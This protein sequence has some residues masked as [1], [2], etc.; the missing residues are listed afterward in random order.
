MKHERGT[1]LSRAAA[2]IIGDEIL[3][4]KVRDENTFVLAKTLFERGVSL[5]KVVVI[6]DIVDEIADTVRAFSNQFDF[7]FTSGGIGPTHD[8]KT[9]EAVAKAFGLPL[10]FQEAIIKRLTQFHNKTLSDVKLNDAQKKMLFLPKPCE[11]I[12][13]NALWLPL[14]VVKN[15]YV[16]PGV[17]KLFEALLTEVKG[18]FNGKVKTRI[19][20]YTKKS[21]GDIAYDLGRLQSAYPQI[22]IGSY[23][24]Y[25]SPKYRVMVSLEGI[26][27]DLVSEVATKVKNAIDG[28]C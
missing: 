25:E 2:I 9:Y 21:E 24:K 26:S 5:Q 15:V 1:K 14:V 19:L 28:F 10:E 18:R 4:G 7:V 13:T 3:T 16:F 12:P 22:A 17:P 23:P 8:D 11:I 20:L 27:K 6:P